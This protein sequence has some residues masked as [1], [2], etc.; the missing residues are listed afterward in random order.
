MLYPKKNRKKQ[1]ILSTMVSPKR[2]HS[3]ELTKNHV[4]V[5]SRENFGFI[6]YYIFVKFYFDIYK[7]YKRNF[8]ERCNIILVKIENC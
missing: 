6:F 1:I 5:S 4:R 7:R 8:G 3:C 2:S